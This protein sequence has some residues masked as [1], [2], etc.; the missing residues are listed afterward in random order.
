MIDLAAGFGR[1]K[2]VVG[3]ERTISPE[4]LAALAAAI[5]GRPEFPAASRRYLT[6]FIAWR[7]GIGVIN[8]V[9]SN[10]ARER[11]LEHLLYLHF[12]G[13]AAE[14]EYGASFERLAGLAEARDQIGASA[15][16][17]R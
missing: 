15:V 2:I 17:T 14:R 5:R 3:R 7:A 1:Q 8:K 13:D 6:E 16:R 12:A 9:V 11:I 10:L 4:G